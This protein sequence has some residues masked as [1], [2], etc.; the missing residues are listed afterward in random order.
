MKQSNYNKLKTTLQSKFEWNEARLKYITVL[1]VS[2]IEVATVN[3][4]RISLMMNPLVKNQSNYRNLQ[5]FFQNFQMDYDEYARI[6]LELFT[7][8]MATLCCCPPESIFG[9]LF[10]RSFNPT[11]NKAFSTFFPF[12][13][14]YIA[15]YQRKLNFF[16]RKYAVTA[17]VITTKTEIIIITVC[18]F[19]VKIL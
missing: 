4:V 16:Q 14:R 2:L 6:I 19:I 12:R 17:A 9:R 3:L 18:F 5:R 10:I 1:I 7:M 11:L 15:V 8:A 13:C